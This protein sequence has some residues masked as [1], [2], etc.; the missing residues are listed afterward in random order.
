MRFVDAD[1]AVGK[2]KPEV[3]MKKRRQQAKEVI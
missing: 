1:Q 3:R 2:L